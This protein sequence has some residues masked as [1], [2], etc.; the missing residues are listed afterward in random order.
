MSIDSALS[1]L[2]AASARDRL[3]YRPRLFDAASPDDRA[4][5]EQLIAS[6]EVVFA[7]DAI[8]DQL[9]EL[10]AVRTPNKR[11]TRAELDAKA[12]AYLGDRPAVEYGTWVY[13]PWSRALI[14]VL[15]RDEYR[16]LRTSRNRY[17]ISPSEQ[18]RLG[19]A[20][21][22]V[23]GLSVGL[24]SAITL[25]LE[26]IG[27]ELRLADFD[28]LALSNM[29][30]LRSSAQNIGVNK[31]VIAARE[32]AEIDPYLEIR[33]F[34]R[35]LTEEN[36]EA[37]LTDGGKLDL[38][39]EECDDLFM[40]IFVREGARR[41]G[42]PVIMETNERGMLDVERFDIEPDRPLLHGLL[43]N[44]RSAEVKGLTTREKAPYVLRIIGIDTISLRMRTSLMEIEQSVS[45]W[46][47]LASGVSLGGASTTTAARKILLDQFRSS[48]RFFVDLDSM[49]SDG[50][51]IALSPDRSL[52][53]ILSRKATPDLALPPLTRAE[54]A[55]VSEDDIRTLV[56]YGSLAP[57]AGNAQPWKF[58]AQGSSIRCRI[59]ASRAWVF[60]D[61]RKL[62]SCVALGAAVENMSLAAAAMGLRADI[63]PFPDPAD[64][65]TVCDVHVSHVSPAEAP[66]EAPPLSAQIAKRVSNRRRTKREPLPEGTIEAL[67]E[68][69][70]SS[71][72][73]ILLLTEP[74]A[75]DEAAALV[76]AIDRL[77][78]LS[79]RMHRELT[80]E[81]RWTERQVEATRDGVDIAT[82][83]LEPVDLAG[84]RIAMSWPS[85]K[86]LHELGGGRGLEKPAKDMIGAASAMAL[87]TV[88]GVSP[89][90]YFTGG[91]VL[92]QVWLK[93]TELGLAVHP[94]SGITY[95]FARLEQGG[96][97]ELSAEQIEILQGL[98]KRYLALFD[99]KP[100]EEAEILLF[101]ISLA[102]PS[103]LRSLRRPLE[104]V[105]T[106]AS[107]ADPKAD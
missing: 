75:L 64:E 30:R 34:E 90:S 17:K 63:I 107:A 25:V 73:R 79:E 71:G 38:V 27:R 22:G 15:P 95:L 74:A 6:G 31:A 76:G 69:A 91:R 24:A 106:F 19:A 55:E 101:R 36:L 9:R 28:E 18:A 77:M 60:L 49:V 78:Y 50:A 103:A 20:R 47:Q 85:M 7:S 80:H 37:F 66:A 41:L 102:G 4:A 94:M 81:V 59:D 88:P 98:R 45:S 1:P 58:F 12:A 56:A 44:V 39:V 42:I 92:E 3:G 10:M 89:K 72:G 84:M 35:G 100:G 53:E 61:F 48:G 70:R 65:L 26:S 40:K 93:A 43:D 99:V 5:L 83:E 11:M 52:D 2:L 57:S 46:P 32:I 23:V 62:A 97:E 67:E 54:R 16:E 86:L 14:H 13:Y 29:N 87:V 8:A 51:E 68:T 96:G 33:V 104:D 21:I 82:L 105:L